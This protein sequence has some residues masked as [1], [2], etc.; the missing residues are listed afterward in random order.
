MHKILVVDDE[1]EIRDMIM[2]FL[3]IKGYEVYLAE[4]GLETIH[5]MTTDNFDLLIMDLQMPGIKGQEIIEQFRKSK[6][7]IPVIILTGTIDDD[8]FE[9]LRKLGFSSNDII[10]KPVDLFEI[11]KKIKEKLPDE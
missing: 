4:D 10:G 7:E 3:R 9:I 11:L 8:V 6:K 1:K 5:K 2:R